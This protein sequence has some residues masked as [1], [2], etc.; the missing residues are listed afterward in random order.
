MRGGGGAGGHH[1]GGLQVRLA[2]SGEPAVQGRHHHPLP[3]PAHHQ[4]LQQVMGELLLCC[5]VLKEGDGNFKSRYFY[6]VI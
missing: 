4:H 5:N 3:H 1:D 2:Q 6:H